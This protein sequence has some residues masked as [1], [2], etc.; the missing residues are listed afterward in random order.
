[1]KFIHAA[2]FHLCSGFITT[3]LKSEIANAHREQLWDTFHNIIS[4]CEKENADILLLPGD[5]FE[6]AYARVS[7]IKRIIDA[8]SSIPSTRVF[9]APGDAD[10]LIGESYYNIVQLPQNTHIFRQYEE[11]YIPELNTSVH[12]FGWEKNRYAELPF[13]FRPLDK[14]RINL[15][16]LHCDLTNSSDYL[17]IS[18]EMLASIGF[19]YAA[20]GHVHKATQVK[21]NIFYSGSPEPL[22]FGEEG[23][24]GYVTGV[25]EEKKLSLS[26]MVSNRR[27]FAT[28][29]LKIT[30]DM[31]EELIKSQVRQ[32]CGDGMPKHVYRLVF[33]GIKHPLI[34]I[35]EI[36]DDFMDDF[37]SVDYYDRTVPDYDI[38]KIY[39]DNKDNIIGKFIYSLTQDATK[40]PIAYKALLSGLEALLYRQE[41]SLKEN[42]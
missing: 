20:L 3:A 16:C 39:Q 19:D 40:D 31:N 33:T 38:K 13:S 21:N 36:M 7:D 32:A 17:P 26:F 18:E 37:Y 2:D 22:N 1:M 23:R 15:L 34:D 9:I 11:V 12:G 8:L 27:E 41:G 42:V 29:Q 25:F 30:S 14:D 4:T 6:A 28:L 35:T 5:I 10:S 24:H